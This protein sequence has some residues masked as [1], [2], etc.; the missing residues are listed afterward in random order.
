MQIKIPSRFCLTAVGK[1]T[2]KKTTNVGDD[3]AKQGKFYTKQ[4]C[5]IL[6]PLWKNIENIFKTGNKTSM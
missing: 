2:I 1:A 5:K 4:E 6:Q 3:G